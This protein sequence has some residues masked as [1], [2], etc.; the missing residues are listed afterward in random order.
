[1]STEVLTFG[2][3]VLVLLAGAVWVGRWLGGRLTAPP[4]RV[5]ELLIVA[6]IAVGLLVG[7]FTGAAVLAGLAWAAVVSA[8]ALLMVR[9]RTVP[10]VWAGVVGGL[11]AVQAGV[12]TFVASTFSAFEAPREHALAW[13]PAVLTG[14]VKDLGG[15]ASESEPPLWARMSQQAGPLALLLVL[16]TGLAVAYLVRRGSRPSAAAAA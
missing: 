11:V 9:L 16:A 4:L 15:P 8:V 14:A 1:M 5:T 2:V 10:A 6:V 7:R 13:L 12:I 3:M